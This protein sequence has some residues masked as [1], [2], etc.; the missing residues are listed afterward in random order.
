LAR[1]ARLRLSRASTD[2]PTDAPSADQSS[3]HNGPSH[4]GVRVKG[5]LECH[6]GGDGHADEGTGDAVS[7]RFWTISPG[8]Y[9]LPLLNIWMIE[10]T[11]ATTASRKNTQFMVLSAE[12]GASPDKPK[13]E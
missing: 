8:H 1:G 2:V 13:I 5:K 4:G 9:D 3:G 7:I 12:L 11:Q 6:N 10:P